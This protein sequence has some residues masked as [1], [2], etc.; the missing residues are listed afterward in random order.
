MRLDHRWLG[1]AIVLA[2]VSTLG[3]C[4]CGKKTSPEESSC[5]PRF[6]SASG[7]CEAGAIDGKVRLD[8]GDGHHGGI[9][10]RLGDGPRE[11]VTA[12]D[13]RFWFDGVEP[14]DHTL[15]LKSPSGAVTGVEVHVHAG[16]VARIGPIS[17]DRVTHVRVEGRILLEGAGEHG[18]TMVRVVGGPEVALT[19]DDGSFAFP[20]LASGNRTL[21][22][23][24]PGYADA[25]REI[26]VPID[27]MT[28]VLDPWTL[29]AVPAGGTISGRVTLAGSG[30]AAVDATV[31]IAGNGRSARTGGDGAFEIR[32]V[33]AG[34]WEVRAGLPGFGPAV[35]T[36]V[37]VE[38][39]RATELS[40]VVARGGAASWV[41]GFA[42]RIGASDHAG[43]EVTLTSGD[44][45]FVTTTRA[46][47][48]WEI[49]EIPEG[50]YDLHAAFDGLEPEEVRGLAVTAGPNAAPDVDLGTAVKMVDGLVSWSIALPRTQR[51]ISQIYDADGTPGLWRF[52]LE[53]RTSN[54]LA[55]GYFY[56]HAFDQDERYMTIASA[57][58]WGALYR[59]TIADGSIERVTPEVGDYWTWPRFTFLESSDGGFYLLRPEAV[60]AEPIELGCEIWYV[61]EE[62]SLDESGEKVMFRFYTEC[63]QTLFAL[64]DLEEGFVGFAGDEFYGRTTTR[65]VSIRWRGGWPTVTFRA[66]PANHAPSSMGRA[67]AW[68]VDLDARESFRLSDSISGFFGNPFVGTLAYAEDLEDGRH[69]LTRVDLGTGDTTV[70]FGDAGEY[71]YAGP[72]HVVA[73]PHDAD[74]PLRWFA[75]D[76]PEQ[77]VL[78]DDV[79]E[80]GL[81]AD[82]GT[83]ACVGS[84]GSLYAFDPVARSR[85]L[86]DTNPSGINFVGARF[87]I[88]S[89]GDRENVRHLDSSTTIG[90][91][92]L[93]WSEFR[94]TSVEGIWI[95]SSAN[96]GTRALN[97]ATGSSASIKAPG[98]PPPDRCEISPSM[99]AAVCL[100]ACGSETCGVVYDLVSGTSVNLGISN[101]YPW[102]DM[103]I[104]WAPGEDQ[105]AFGNGFY[106]VRAGG[107]WT[108]A[109]C[110]FTTDAGE[111]LTVDGGTTSLWVLWNDSVWLCDASGETIDAG[112]VSYWRFEPTAMPGT[113][114]VVTHEGVADLGAGSFSPFDSSLWSLHLLPEG[115]F[116]VSDFNEL[117]GIQAT[118]WE[119]LADHFVEFVELGGANHVLTFENG[120]NVLWSIGG[121]TLTRVADGLEWAE[122]VAEDK[123]ILFGWP[124]LFE[125]RTVSFL[126]L[127]TGEIETVAVASEFESIWGDGEGHLYFEVAKGFAVMSLNEKT[128]ALTT[129]AE[130]GQML[131][132]DSAGRMYFEAGGI[133]WWAD[134][135]ETRG[136]LRAQDAWIVDSNEN[137]VILGRT[138]PDA[139]HWYE[140]R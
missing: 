75:I 136:V 83:V 114:L 116:G 94:G 112:Y 113:S 48:R 73:L 23:Q 9:R 31:I 93:P 27:P 122:Q 89:T 24:H 51:A 66:G 127:S 55:E 25:E 80:W 135:S 30:A 117:V 107:T 68:W 90:W 35:V 133:V 85:T 96:E 22:A 11:A 45:A 77:G 37:V 32:N 87:V 63:G 104:S 1:T 62:I 56:P 58:D 126:T 97:L 47:G 81:D 67:E 38:A 54:L 64:A 69:P 49:A 4:S 99:S 84:D 21:R 61:S 36:G 43:I 12:S 14:G 108:G 57:D 10:V 74:E 118:G 131:D 8:P 98:E 125:G 13:G 121:G 106:A 129:L 134:G 41:E 16:E 124:N 91:D 101:W 137:S 18:G 46:D 42:R 139:T 82:S 44:D 115:V 20:A 52:D 26:A 110:D 65:N 2:L 59:L 78:C 105:V 86:L 130:D 92:T 71:F 128:G 40:L 28:M 19:R 29:E 33:P 103:L 123:A 95:L 100:E 79:H 6:L 50:L 17:L 109:A 60:E 34:T 39:G 76:G 15:M 120:G 138:G 5:N 72:R 140:A 111:A 132:M 3:G 119:K 53:T 7:A 102:G 88:W 70:V